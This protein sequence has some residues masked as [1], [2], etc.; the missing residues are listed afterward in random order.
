MIAKFETRD[1]ATKGWELD[2]TDYLDRSENHSLNVWLND[3]V[4]CEMMKTLFLHKDMREHFTVKSVFGSKLVSTVDAIKLKYFLSKQEVF[5]ISYFVAQPGA[6]KSQYV[7]RM[8]NCENAI[9]HTFTDLD[10]ILVLNGEEHFVKVKSKTALVFKTDIQLF[11]PK[12]ETK[13]NHRYV[14][15]ELAK[16]GSL[17]DV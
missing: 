10:V 17:Q 2:V 1:W 12:N 15:V 3:S 9:L 14:I 8:E 13:N 7:P 16:K 5:G 4:H 11:K 6:A